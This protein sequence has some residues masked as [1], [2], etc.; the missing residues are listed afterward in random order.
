MTSK[1]HSGAL[2]LI[3]FP[4]LRSDEINRD[5]DVFTNQFLA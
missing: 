4:F 1:S 2:P 3:K 5:L